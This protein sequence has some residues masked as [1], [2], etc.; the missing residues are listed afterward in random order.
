MG[1]AMSKGNGYLTSKQVW[2]E[3][4]AP[5]ELQKIVAALSPPSRALW[6]HPPLAVAWLPRQ[7]TIEFAIRAHEQLGERAL[8]LAHEAARRMVHKDF[9]GI[10]RAL[11]R[12]ATVD[13]VLSKAM[14]YYD[15]YTRDSG[16]LIAKRTGPKSTFNRYEGLPD[17]T[18]IDCW[19]L[20]GAGLGILEL[21]GASGAQ[22]TRRSLLPD[23]V[24]ELAYA[25]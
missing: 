20:G 4:L 14:K 18:E 12:L 17:A 5:E 25:W 6:D 10:Y 24:I 19:F 21:V 22:V 7:H 3:L 15:Q 16:T 23:G 9:T 1:E 2:T 11:I 13:Y 8:S